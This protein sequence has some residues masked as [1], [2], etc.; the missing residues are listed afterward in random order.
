V[1][2]GLWVKMVRW[3]GAALVA[4]C[5]SVPSLVSAD[6]APAA[7]APPSLDLLL[8]PHQAG[9]KVD[10]VDIVMTIAHPGVA[11][12]QT[13]VHMPLVVASIPTQ[14]YDGDAIHAHDASGDLP[15]T[16][17]EEPTTPFL[18]Y[19]DWLAG[20]ATSGDVTL[21]YRA[22][23]RVVNEHTRNGPLF[24][25]R[26]EA[27]GLD[28]A[29]FTFVAPPVAEGPYTLHVHWDM[30]GM[31]AGS[32]GIWSLGEGDVTIVRPAEIL[33]ETFYYAGPV[34]S[35][36]PGGIDRFG[37]YWLSNPPFDAAKAAKTIDK[38]FAYVSNFFHDEGQPYRVFVRKNPY[39]HGGGTALARSFLFGY[40]N[41]EE[42]SLS[43]EELISHEM[44]HN[45]PTMSGDHSDT[46]WYTE[47][48]AEYYSILLSYRAGLISLDEFVKRINDRADGYYKNP[49]QALSNHEAEKI[50]WKDARAGHVPYG[51]GWVYLG[52]VDA[53]IRA[54]SQGKHNL[55]NVVLA[56]LDRG[57]HGQSVTVDDWQ[58]LVAAEIGPKARSE[59]A[60]M[61][62]GKIL[63]PTADSF[64]P[65]LR[66]VAVAESQEDLGFDPVVYMAAPRTI[67]NLEP[68]SAADLAGL[69]E[70]DT[71]VEGTDVSDP[72]FRYD[73]P[74]T[75]TVTRAG[76]AMTFKFLPRGKTV[77]GYHW[78]RNPGVPETQCHL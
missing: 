39:P 53:E 71:V 32:R 76:K 27:G 74:V 37:V 50:Y 25:L 63:V 24:D 73:A 31:P 12:G 38:L 45:W 5:V 11:A 46:S 2:V 52:I 47:G 69:R 41:K 56:L 78:V 16:L 23:P 43:F 48:T 17:K 13:L 42:K 67:K 68:G 18:S 75:I 30:A 35:Y 8:K 60:D 77:I 21:T 10:Y 59:Y 20:R 58:N 26:E 62:A 72:S 15:L 34:K 9:G 49:L 57:R 4:A 40:G 64:G 19:R 65:C 29:G 51:R 14:R 54:A 44:V 61:I 55:D 1:V 70:G 36:P 33:A 6:T 3:F 7:G 28:G 66:P 22:V